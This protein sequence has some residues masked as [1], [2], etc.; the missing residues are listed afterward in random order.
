MKERSNRTQLT[1]A[2]KAYFAM[3]PLPV[4]RGNSRLHLKAA[5]EASLR[6]LGTDYIDLYLCHGWDETVPVDETLRAL[7]DLR[8]DG[9]IQYTGV[10]NVRAHEV[11]AAL[12]EAGRLGAS[13]FDG[14][15]PRYNLL[16]REAEE[17]LF[18]LARRFGL[19]AMVY[20]PLAGGLLTGKHRPGAPPVSG[21]RFTLGSTGET[22]RA[23]YWHERLL[24]EAA[25]VLNA[26]A[27]HGLSPVTASVAWTIAN[28][29]VT[30][31][32]V[33][34]SRVEQL[35][36][37]LKATQITLPPTLTETLDQ[38]WFGLPRTP[39]QLDT[40]RNHDFYGPV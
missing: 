6:R 26:A 40:P 11:T 27:A 31:A 33:G 5:C 8:R 7:E 4:H 38:V 22:Y 19:G 35:A 30:A 36:D 25:G 14:L 15:Q 18:P 29:D 3:G 10:S 2:T 12:L 17:S 23:R 39:P 1:V 20:N 13:G 21:T 32:I 16:Y 28:R 34:V 24:H 9:K 37:Q